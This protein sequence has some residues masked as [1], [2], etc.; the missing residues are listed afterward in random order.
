[1][2]LKKYLKKI[3][4]LN[5]FYTKY[6]WREKR[7]CNGR[8]NPELTFYVIRRSDSQVGLFSLVLTTLGYINYA[9]DQ[10]YIPIVDLT[11]EGNAYLDDSVGSNVWEYYFEQPCGYSLKDITKSKHIILG[12]GIIDWTIP[13]PKDS[14]VHDST[15]EEIWKETAHKYLRIKKEILEEKKQLKDILLGEENYLGVLLRGTDYV[16]VRP[17]N[18]PVQPTVEEAIQVIDRVLREKEY[19][20]IYLA[21]ED[22]E[23]YGKMKETYGQQLVAMDVERYIT[24]NI[25]IFW[26]CYYPI[27]KALICC[28]LMGIWFVRC[29]KGITWLIT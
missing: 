5:D 26:Q 17:K 4:W 8:E 21:T 25:I 15:E 23:I 24:K 7:V 28:K 1:M 10:G 18:H 9:L 16:N 27:D 2:N 19:Q 3:K 20:K 14:M 13:F 12:N 11:N 6:K 29:W 22:N